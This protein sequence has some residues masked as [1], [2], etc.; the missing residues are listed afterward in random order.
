[1]V[2]TISPE[3]IELPPGSEATLRYQTW[4][5]Y[6]ALIASRRDDAAIKIRFNART[7]E[8]SI[9][10]PLPAH[11]N[12]SRTLADLVTTLL[13]HQK[14]DWHGFD[15]VTLKRFQQ[16]GAEPD[17]CF[18]IQNW[19]AV[20]GKERIDLA[21]D[22]PPD[23]AIEMDLT[24]LTDLAVYQTLAIPELWIYRQGSLKIYQL[25]PQGYQERSVSPTFPTVDVK[26]LLPKYV[27]RAWTAGSS[28]ALRE[29]ENYL[30]DC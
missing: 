24:S 25:T 1:M 16:A 27:E 23:L 15:P 13:R 14:R 2:V 11:G 28:V 4:T 22:P 29:F 18:Y 5:D 12:R 19:R 21:Q 30:N 26:N 17:A 7:Q 20:L 9:M 3:R 6:E 10:A 8:I